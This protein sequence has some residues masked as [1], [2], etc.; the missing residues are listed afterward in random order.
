MKTLSVKNPWAY[1]ICSG[2]KDIE[3]RSWPT[4][5]RGKILIHV[6]AKPDPSGPAVAS[7]P[8][9]QSIIGYVEIAGCIQDSRS[10]WAAPGLWHWVLKNPVLFDRPILGVK[11]T[12]SLW[13]FPLERY[14]RITAG[15]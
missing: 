12:L 2:K 9:A 13:E 10:A 11:G 6:P 3:N 8:P 14:P 1:L 15:L 5:Y 7:L 4:S